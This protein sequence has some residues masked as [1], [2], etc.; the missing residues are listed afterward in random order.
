MLHFAKDHYVE[1]MGILGGFAWGW[2]IHS[3]LGA[4][5]RPIGRL[6]QP[7]KIR[8]EK[9]PTPIVERKEPTGDIVEMFKR[10]K[11]A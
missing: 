4:V 11:Q 2:I 8:I 1:I 10:R 3:I 5:F 7:A 9:I 6:L